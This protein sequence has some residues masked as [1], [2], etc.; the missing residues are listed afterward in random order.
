MP[1]NAYTSDTWTAWVTAGTSTAVSPGLVWTNWVGTANTAT[2]ATYTNAVWT[3]WV[4]NTYQQPAPET[5]EQRAAREQ[6]WAQQQREWA[7]QEAHRAE[8]R[9]RTEA[10]RQQARA[11]AETLLLEHLTEEQA[12]EYRRDQSFRVIS[13]DGERVYRVKRGWS[14]NVE[15]IRPDGRVVARYC[16]HP[17]DWV[18]EEDNMLA[19]KLLLETDEAAFNRIANVTR[20]AA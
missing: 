10:E 19:Q 9:R 20:F 15:L 11:T 5:A 4:G 14:G 16:I 13:A 1:T 6:R 7:A 17:R 8:E 3:N 2:S 12:V 18:P